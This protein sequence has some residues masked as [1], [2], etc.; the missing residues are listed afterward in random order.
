MNSYPKPIPNIK[1]PECGA[2][3]IIDGLDF[4]K[5]SV[6]T[7]PDKSTMTFTCKQCGQPIIV[8]RDQVAVSPDLL[9]R[10][11][12]LL[13]TSNGMIQPL[14]NS[15]CEQ[16]IIK[17]PDG[18]QT[19][20][21]NGTAKMQFK[22]PKTGELLF[23]ATMAIGK[24][25][26]FLLTPGI[27]RE[28][29]L[30]QSVDRV[31]AISQRA[32][33]APELQD[34]VQLWQRPVLGSDGRCSSIRIAAV[35][36]SPDVLP[37]N[38]LNVICHLF[39]I[40]DMSQYS[41]WLRQMIDAIEQS[42]EGDFAAAILDY[43][44]ACEMFIGD[45]VRATLRETTSFDDHLINQVSGCGVGER[46]A[47]L[48]PLLTVDPSA[49]SGAQQSWERDVKSMRDNNVVHVLRDVNADECRQA[50]DSAYWFVRALQSQC[51]FEAGKT[52]D[53]WAR[54]TQ[55]SRPE[56]PGEQTHCCT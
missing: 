41:P 9:F 4:C 54:P 6:L 16:L 36:S 19:T 43:A 17:L 53:Y 48:L 42:N 3:G 34:K 21:T 26:E 30:P 45:Y 13:G 27:Y 32:I 50:H 24:E 47:R 15:V 40:P 2:E 11:I 20:I 14:D 46:V 18:H 1:C 22:D 35:V 44:R 56:N 10:T 28:Y 49:Y 25:P 37:E 7:N 39:A 31:L 5:F 8:S 38:Q 23:E 51:K 33:V 29:R 12:G 55:E 52:W